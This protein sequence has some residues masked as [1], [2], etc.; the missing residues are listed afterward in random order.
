MGMA[1]FMEARFAAIN[2]EYLRSQGQASDRSSTLPVFSRV[3]RLFL[4]SVILGLGAYLVIMQEA[5]AGVI[6]A[7]SILTSRALTP[8]D[9]VISNWKGFVGAREA[10]KRLDQ[11]LTLLPE[12]RLPLPFPKPNE[13]L[14]V[15]A[16]SANAPGQA[17][18]ILQDVTFGL[19]RGDGLG[20][21]GPSGSGKSTLARLIV[22]VW[23]PTGGKI[24]LDGAGL[25]QWAPE[26]L[27]RHIGYLPQDVELFDGTVAENISRFETALDPEAVIAAAKA[28][29]AHGLITSLPEG[30]ETRIGEAG[31]ALSAGQRQRIALARALY[32]DSFLVVLDEPNSNLDNAG[33]E[34]LT[35]AL[36]GVRQRGGIA[37]VIAHR[38]SALA[39]LDQILVMHQ[40]RQRA[41]GPKEE[42]LRGVARSPS[43]PLAVV[44]P[45]Q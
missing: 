30:Y 3:I 2:E 28:A 40:G 7:S 35:Q 10:R 43:V 42:V 37:I 14:A 31:A 27:S 41:L 1:P 13:S 23:E 17:R 34:A 45:A 5:S 20:I 32:R 8:V 19:T 33:E 22:G 26:A 4:Q 38:P 29:G 36:H 15:S 18:R 24:R 25:D 39:A 6:I 44:R 21:I 16:I 11:L 12:R 9:L